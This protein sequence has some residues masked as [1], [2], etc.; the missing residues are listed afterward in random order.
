MLGRRLASAA[1]LVPIVVAVLLL[2]RPWIDAFVVVVALLVGWET[3]AL[4]ASAGL[5]GFPRYGTALAAGF[6]VVGATVSDRVSAP[7]LA[8]PALGILLAGAAALRFQDPRAGLGAWAA[9]AFG[10]AYVGFLGFAPLLMTIAP[11]VPSGAP[12]ASLDAGRGWLVVLVAGVWSYDSFA[13][14]FGRAFGRRRFLQHISPAK[15]Y[16]GLYGGLAGAVGVSALVL[17]GLGRSPLEGVPVG[18]LL[19][20]AAQAGDLAE[21]ML[22]RAANAKDSGRLI[23]GHGGVLDRVDSFLFAA[24]ILVGYLALVPR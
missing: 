12:L 2:G 22:K 9:T 6:V 14:A 18:L 23:P 13:Y 24:P 8:V 19:G 11:Q 21:S 10:A 5:R 17:A 3:F 16:A 15:T 4:L 20:I 1:I 7:L